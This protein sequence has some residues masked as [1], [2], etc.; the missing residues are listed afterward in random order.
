MRAPEIAVAY[1][2]LR[3]EKLSNESVNELIIYLFR[4][5]EIN[6]EQA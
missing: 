3:E 1:F 2:L 5:K 6:I 4:K